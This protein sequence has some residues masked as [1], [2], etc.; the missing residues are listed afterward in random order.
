MNV[1][2]AY[3]AAISTQ[4]NRR[5]A[6]HDDGWCLPEYNGPNVTMR[7]R[8]TGEVFH[9]TRTWARSADRWGKR[10]TFNA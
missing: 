8:K 6:A 10:V 4:H 1:T 7:N 2:E 3:K 9:G 5:N